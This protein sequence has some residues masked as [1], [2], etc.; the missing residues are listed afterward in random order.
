MDGLAESEIF[1]VLSATTKYKDLLHI[2]DAY[3]EIGSYKLIFTKLDE[4]EACGNLL[5]VRMHTNAPMSYVTYGQNVPD[6]IE[7][8][9]PQKTV[10][11]ILGGKKS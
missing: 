2:A 8:F 3:K 9:N 10:K 6:D 11:L 4:T 5:N 1:L 7:T